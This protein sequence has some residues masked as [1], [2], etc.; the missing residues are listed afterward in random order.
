MNAPRDETHERDACEV[1]RAAPPS[2]STLRR[3]RVAW[4]AVAARALRRRRARA[5]PRD[6]VLHWSR[7]VEPLLRLGGASSGNSARLLLDGDDAMESI[8]Q[9]IDEAS[10]R[11]WVDMYIIEPDQVGRR[12]LDAL[13]RAAARGCEVLLIVDA[14]GSAGLEEDHV[15]PLRDAGG[16]FVR[17]N[18]L[19][20]WPRR[21]P[22][23]RRDHRKVIIIDGR[24]AY[25]GGMNL[26]EDY[27]G[28]RH[29]NGRFHDCHL[30]L[31]GPCVRDLASVVDATLRLAT[32]TRLSLPRRGEEDGHVF[33]QVLASSGWK[34][35]RSIQRAMRFTVR[36]A[37]RS[38]LITTPYFVPPLRLRRAMIRAARA[39][40]DVRVLTAGD[41]DVPI[42]R[43]AARHIYGLFLRSGVRI[44]E[45]FDRTL[46]AK[47][48]VVDGLYCTVGTFN[49]DTWSDK[50]N[51]EVNVAMLDAAVAEKLRERFLDDL[52]H[53]REV[54]M[55]DWARRS[56][57]TR[58]LD[59]LAYQL[60]RL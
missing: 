2:R 35:R 11:V 30:E 16:S 1:E 28:P 33:V 12:T 38:C 10:R 58:L 6:I 55:K 32:R 22:M 57:W 46:H 50:R 49:L 29:G 40:V 17:F 14:V 15:K 23:L 20:R 43:R 5:V 24:A 56:A 4:R 27:A 36:H 51:L 54:T 41:S 13:T 42:V 9:A 60:L 52:T 26:S 45:M 34:S 31:R 39:G 53:S 19:L 37:V 47:T 7:L 59:W 21:G 8:W 3:W 48:M 25:C 18:P 44:F